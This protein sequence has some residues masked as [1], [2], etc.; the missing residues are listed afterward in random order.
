MKP[1][2]LLLA[3]LLPRVELEASS[4]SRGGAVVVVVVAVEGAV[5]VVVVGLVFEIFCFF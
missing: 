4:R 2:S 3:L 5:E 1:N